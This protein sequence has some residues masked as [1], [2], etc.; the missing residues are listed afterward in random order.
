MPAGERS[1]RRPQ[2]RR[3]SEG[4][5]S[6]GARAEPARPRPRRSHALSLFTFRVL[7]GSFCRLYGSWETCVSVPCAPGRSGPPALPLAGAVASELRSCLALQRC[8]LK[9]EEHLNICLPT[10]E[11]PGR[12][13]C[14]FNTLQYERP[15]CSSKFIYIYIATHV[16]S[17][18]VKTPIYLLILCV[19]FF[20]SPKSVPIHSVFLFRWL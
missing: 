7:A 10:A 13:L 12:E 5:T 16:S 2:T 1:R 4:G 15:P 8:Q 18:K 11:K 6:G 3:M 9:P 20:L 19:C 14:L 17:K